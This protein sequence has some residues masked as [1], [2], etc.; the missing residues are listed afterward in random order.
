[1]RFKEFKSLARSWKYSLKKYFKVYKFPNV[2]NKALLGFNNLVVNPDNLYMS[3]F[4]SLKRDNV[5]MNK[6]V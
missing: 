2:N 5:I 1:M 6:L 3:E 4:S